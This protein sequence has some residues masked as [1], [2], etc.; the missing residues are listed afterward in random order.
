[1]WKYSKD[2]EFSTSSAY[3]LANQGESLES[4]FQGQWIWKLDILPKIVNF[5]WLW[6]H[7]SIPMI[8]VLTLRASTV[9]DFA[10]YVNV[11]MRPLYT[12]LEIV[13]LVNSGGNWRS[14]P[15]PFSLITSFAGNV[16]NWLKTNCLSIVGHSPPTLGTPSQ[17]LEFFYC[18]GK[19][20][21]IS[22]KV[23]LS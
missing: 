15:L 16:E 22:S 19:S 18:V 14:P 4:P 23:W 2:E 5:L 11:E 1:M 8:D 13:W 17:A 9:I 6:F 3:L 21:Q 20:K 12:S 10:Q 7:R